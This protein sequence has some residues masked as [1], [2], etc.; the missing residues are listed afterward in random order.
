MRPRVV[1][2][3]A[4]TV[5]A[6]QATAH[7]VPSV[8]DNN[9]YLKLTPAADRVRLA[10][11]VLYGETPGAQLRATIDR[12]RDGTIADGEA[13]AFGTDVADDVGRAIEI[14]V[15]GRAADVSWSTVAVGMGSPS[16]TAGSFA[17]DLVAWLCVSS[18]APPARHVVVVRD[19]FRLSRPGQTEVKVEDALG[20]TIERARVGALDSPTH[21][22]EL[23][24]T[25]SSLAEDGLEL[26][27]VASDKAPRGGAGACVPGPSRGTPSRSLP[28]VVIAAAAAA[29]IAAIA[30][31]VR[32][33]ARATGPC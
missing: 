25:G 9:R 3:A 15:D 17:V 32:R 26:V 20:I 6:S 8:D 30:A 11:T 10:Y 12:D 14:T 21:E 31:L 33:R 19:R 28:V 29:V 2:V 18:A 24:G 23:F 16:A 1:C 13:Q 5:V 22:L 7:M 4:I 27:F